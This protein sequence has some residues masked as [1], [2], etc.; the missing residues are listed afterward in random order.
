MTTIGGKSRIKRPTQ[1][2]IIIQRAE[3][4]NEFLCI[5]TAIGQ[6]GDSYVYWVGDPKAA[7][8]FD[9]KYAAKCRIRGIEDVPLSRVYRSV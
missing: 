8:K 1:P 4:I 3:G 7:T 2:Q 6:P 5:E 9:S